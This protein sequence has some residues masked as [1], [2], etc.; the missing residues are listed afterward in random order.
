MKTCTAQIEIMDEWMISLVCSEE[1]DKTYEDGFQLNRKSFQIQ[2]VVL[3]ET[4]ARKNDD[5]HLS[6]ISST[7]TK[8]CP[9]VWPPFVCILHRKPIS[10]INCYSPADETELDVFYEELGKRNGLREEYK[11]MRFGS[12]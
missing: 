12:G 8:P 3:H 10:I 5:T 7:F 1:G 6:S 2:V 4:K 11:I 9:P